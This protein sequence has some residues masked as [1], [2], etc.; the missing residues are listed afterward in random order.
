MTSGEKNKGQRRQP[1]PTRSLN[2]QHGEKISTL[3]ADARSAHLD[4]VFANGKERGQP[5]PRVPKRTRTR[6]FPRAGFTRTRLSALLSVSFGLRARYTS[7]RWTGRVPNLQAGSLRYVARASLRAGYG[8]FQ[9]PVRKTIS[10]RTQCQTPPNSELT[11]SLRGLILFR[12]F[13]ESSKATPQ[14]YHE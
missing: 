3:Q 6:A 8:G 9:P 5:C 7:L 2:F 1:N 12:G 13:H 11:P 14:F 4:G 10:R